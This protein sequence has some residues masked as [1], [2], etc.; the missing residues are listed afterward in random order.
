MISHV[1]TGIQDFDKS[2]SFYSALMTELGLVLKFKDAGKPWAGWMSADQP[3]P[4]FVI[5]KPFNGEAAQ[6]GN[7]QMVA[8]LASSRAAVQRAH[9]AALA[10]GGT[11]EGAPGLRPHYHPNYYGAYFRDPDGNKLCVCCHHEEAE[12]G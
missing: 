4:L 3:R 1:F 8:L 12:A 9:A 7:G 5:G 6:H 10:H 2:F 11:C